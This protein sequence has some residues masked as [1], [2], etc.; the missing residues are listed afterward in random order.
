MEIVLGIIVVFL[1]FKSGALSSSL[2]TA[3]TLSVPLAPPPTGAVLT[4]AQLTFAVQGS[5]QLQS[6]VGSLVSTGTGVTSALTNSGGLLSNV[7]SQAFSQAVPIVGAVVGAVAN[8]LLAQ[9]TARL[10]GAIA[11]NQ[12][13][14]T[15]VQA[16]DADI[17]ELVSAYNSGAIGVNANG[18]SSTAATA[19][20]Q[21]DSSLYSFMK[22]NATGPGRA[23]K[24]ASMAGGSPISTTSAPSCNS[25]C[26]AECCVFWNDMNNIMADIYAYLTT[27]TPMGTVLS[28]MVQGG[29]KF[30]IPE[31]VQPPPK[32]GTFQRAS[33]SITLI[34]PPNAA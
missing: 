3:S 13:I 9:H 4:P 26:T 29:I 6:Q 15:S 8:I 22:G 27:G 21:M 18:T 23:W 14:P 7:A 10:K 24:D 11:E 5:T 32:Y 12:L 2:L 30:T 16:F 34:I 1:L 19:L 25:A 20:M 33:Y 31:V 28:T 17:Q